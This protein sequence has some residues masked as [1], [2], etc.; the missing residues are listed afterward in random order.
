MS[1][2][3]CKKTYLAREVVPPNLRVADCE[4]N[5]AFRS[6]DTGQAIDMRLGQ[7]FQA[8]RHVAKDCKLDE[9]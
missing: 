2:L 8:S 6:D 3:L 7:D 1:T 4:E 9:S 5:T